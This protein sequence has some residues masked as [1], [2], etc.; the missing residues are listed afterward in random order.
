MS[1]MGV[2]S[3]S[4]DL[5]WAPLLVGVRRDVKEDA[6]VPGCQLADGGDEDG[7]EE[8]ISGMCVR[9][10]FWWVGRV[11]ALGLDVLGIKSQS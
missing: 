6:A 9:H 11:G 10:S 3:P 2:P 7:Q 8:L 1:R 4:H 5:Q